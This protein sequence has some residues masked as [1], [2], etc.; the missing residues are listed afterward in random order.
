[1]GKKKGTLII[2]NFR[3]R[4]KDLNFSFVK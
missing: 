3:G 2:K 1:M 4:L